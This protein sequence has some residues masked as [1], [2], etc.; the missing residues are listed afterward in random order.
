[1]AD[2][3]VDTYKLNQYAQRISA[4][5]SRINGLDRRLDSLYT[6][7]GLL[8]LWNLIQAD[9]LTCYC[10]RL[11]RCSSY[12]QETSTDF[13]WTEQEL[14]RQDP[15]NFKDGN[16]GFANALHVTGAVFGKS[17]NSLEMA[18]ALEVW[19]AIR[20]EVSDIPQDAQSA[21]EALSWIEKYYGKI[22]G[23]L[24][25]GFEVLV[26]ESLKDAYILT[27]GLL[28][29]DL[30]KE[31]GW[32]IVKD[33]LSGNP[34]LTAICETFD[35]VFEGSAERSEEMNR[36]FY[37]QLKEGDILGATLDVAEGFIDIVIGGS[38][39]VL[40]DVVGGVVDQKIDDTPGVKII[41][42]LVK[43]G[44]GLLGWNDGDGYSVGGLIGGA[45]ESVSEGI[46]VATDFI[47]DTTDVIT[48]AMTDGVKTGINWVKGW[49]D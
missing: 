4:V 3:I 29:G 21:G 30:T 49:F 25:L 26:P 23:W 43:Y 39:E 13:E 35:Y 44:T 24:T 1:M 31:E 7:V 15:V 14:L 46:D 16:V 8:G 10:W 34:K 41:N 28:Q 45:A 18:A 6:K 27:S 20:S 32:E 36:Q 37:E 2:I 40:G 11:N 47:T 22:P 38:V 42:K 19:D 9:A 48:D 12:L 17:P 33:I 5:N